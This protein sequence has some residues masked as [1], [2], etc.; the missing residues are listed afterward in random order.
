MESDL[1]AVLTATFVGHFSLMS[2]VPSFQQSVFCTRTAASQA[3][4]KSYFLRLLW[5]SVYEN[6]DIS[7]HWIA[8]LN[9][10]LYKNHQSE[11]LGVFKMTFQHVARPLLRDSHASLHNESRYMPVASYGRSGFSVE[12]S[13][14]TPTL[15]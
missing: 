2:K 6:K 13:Y 7:I 11:A 8:G 4:L 14:T 1:G 10:L 15:C 12:R 3:I 5:M 9:F